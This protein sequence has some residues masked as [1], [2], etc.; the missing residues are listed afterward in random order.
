[1]DLNDQPSSVS[2]SV[3]NAG[4]PKIFFPIVPG[5][6][7]FNA[8]RDSGAVLADG[9]SFNFFYHF[10]LAGFTNASSFQSNGQ[11]PIK[12][13]QY[14]YRLGNF[15]DASQN[16]VSGFQRI[17]LSATG[18]VTAQTVNLVVSNEPAIIMAGFILANGTFYV[19]GGKST[20]NGFRPFLWTVDEA[21]W[22]VS[23]QELPS[24]LGAPGNTNYANSLGSAIQIKNGQLYIG[25]TDAP[26]ESSSNTIGVYWTV[27]LSTNE[28]TETSLLDDSGNAIFYSVNAIDVNA[29]GQVVVGGMNFVNNQMVANTFVGG[30]GALTFA[31][32]GDNSGNVSFASLAVQG[33]DVYVAAQASVYKNGNYLFTLPLTNIN[34]IAVID[35][36]VY[37]VG[38]DWSHW[39]DVHY[40]IYK[41]DAQ[42]SEYIPLFTSDWRY[43]MQIGDLNFVRSA[44]P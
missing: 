4:P 38:S 21:T 27:D 43:V 19:S 39:P 36:D 30:V 2:F 14:L 31:D 37:S 42:I 35:N 20:E 28:V 16:W 44:V 22:T 34:N 26:D 5:L 13:N 9:F 18:D 40:V 12:T 6:D 7:F 23:E 29:S 25:G 3:T 32:H 15:Y 10:N 8:Y 17:P 11:S 33:D 41:N 1:M 24:H